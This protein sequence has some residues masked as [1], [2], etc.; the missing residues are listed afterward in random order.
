VPVLGH[1]LERSVN[2]TGLSPSFS[3]F[4]CQYHSTPAH[5]SSWVLDTECIIQVDCVVGGVVGKGC[6]QAQRS[7]SEW[8]ALF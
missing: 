5:I 2:G 7:I 1:V 3:G 8:R 4:P 6:A